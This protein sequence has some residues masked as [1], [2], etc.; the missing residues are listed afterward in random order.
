MGHMPQQLGNYPTSENVPDTSPSAV[1]NW[2][3]KSEQHIVNLH[4]DYDTIS[5]S[6]YNRPFMNML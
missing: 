6:L 4:L 2:L 1:A 5:Y 3:L